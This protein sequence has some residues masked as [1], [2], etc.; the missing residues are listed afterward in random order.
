MCSSDLL[1]LGAYPAFAE[2]RST[3]I[4]A[5]VSAA[6]AVGGAMKTAL[7]LVAAAASAV[8]V[9]L[10]LA[11]AAVVRAELAAAAFDPAQ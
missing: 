10:A 8:P 3:A 11:A 7:V 9:P 6:A 1:R 5:P 4:A 2:L